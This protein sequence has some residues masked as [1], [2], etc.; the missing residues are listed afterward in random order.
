MTRFG[1]GAAAYSG[2][3]RIHLLP[4]LSIAPGP[5]RAPVGVR[6][7]KARFLAK[8]FRMSDQ[9]SPFLT[10]FLRGCSIQT[11]PFFASFGQCPI[12]LDHVGPANH[13]PL[14]LRSLM[15]GSR[16]SFMFLPMLIAHM[17]FEVF[18]AIPPVKFLFFQWP[19]PGGC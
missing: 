2:S 19:S 12:H 11:S 1:T 17:I 5:W 15:S 4:S 8:K 6:S 16:I 3:C 10:C 7:E 9:K 13:D 18:C 14:S